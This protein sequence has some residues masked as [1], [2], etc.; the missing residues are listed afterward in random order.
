MSDD[1]GSHG[2]EQACWLDRVCEQCG[3]ILE[4]D[5]E[6]HCRRPVGGEPARSPETPTVS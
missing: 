1:L 4:E 5:G 2:G 6:H 3:A